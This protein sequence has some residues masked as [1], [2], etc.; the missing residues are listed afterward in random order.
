M[1]VKVDSL[2]IAG[3]P[4]GTERRGKSGTTFG[5]RMAGAAV[6]GA[7]VLL[8][9]TLYAVPAHA[10]YV[11]TLTQVGSNVVATGNGTIDLTGLKYAAT[12]STTA[13]VIPHF[14][15]IITGPTDSG[16]VDLY[17]GFSGPT[18]FG[19]GTTPTSA[20]TGSGDLVGITAAAGELAVPSGYLSGSLSD[21]ATYDNATFASL[22]VTPGTYTWTWGLTPDRSFTLDVLVPEPGSLA[23][24]GGSL[25]LLGAALRGRRTRAPDALPDFRAG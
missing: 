6:L 7:A 19:A 21:T 22:G 17:T 11:L 25:L 3:D 14:G 24:F 18:N 13:E 1:P 16:L 5:K 4:L 15:A 9:S 2:A 12:P 23:I 20:S 8:G 10:D